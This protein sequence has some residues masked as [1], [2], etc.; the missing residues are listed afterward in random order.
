MDTFA[1]DVT[2]SLTHTL[3]ARIYFLPSP[4]GWQLYRIEGLHP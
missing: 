3:T 1:L 2:Q 4:Q